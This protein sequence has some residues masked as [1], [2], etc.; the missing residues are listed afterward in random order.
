MPMPVF[1]P[2]QNGWTWSTVKASLVEAVA[3]S[4]YGDENN[5]GKLWF[6][7]ENKRM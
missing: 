7:S 6:D 5:V 2:K 4:W 1:L 3:V